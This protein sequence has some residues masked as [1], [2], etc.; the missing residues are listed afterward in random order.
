MRLTKQRLRRLDLAL[1]MD[2]VLYEK[3]R[4]LQAELRREQEKLQRMRRV[5]RV[6]QVVEPGVLRALQIETIHTT[7]DGTWVVVK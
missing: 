5:I 2:D 4:R 1:S 7:H 3:F 6:D